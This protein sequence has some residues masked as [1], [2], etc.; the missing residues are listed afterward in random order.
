MLVPSRLPFVLSGSEPPKRT[1]YTCVAFG[2]EEDE[3]VSSTSAILGGRR[4]S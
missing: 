4:E 3:E 2:K 1:Y